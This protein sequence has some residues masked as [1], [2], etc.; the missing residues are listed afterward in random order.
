MQNDQLQRFRELLDAYCGSLKAS[1]NMDQQPQIKASELSHIVAIVACLCEH[2]ISGSVA[3]DLSTLGLAL[4][5][6]LES[7]KLL[8]AE[9]IFDWVNAYAGDRC[10]V[11]HDTSE[12]SG[13]WYEGCN[14]GYALHHDAEW[15]EIAKQDDQVTKSV[16][17]KLREDNRRFQIDMIKEIG[18][19]PST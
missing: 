9:Q 2:V 13:G 5:H 1:Q 6:D 10:K 8:S 16:V 19:W 18:I 12:K 14:S 11:Y 4:L 17:E 15:Q 7:E 3:Q